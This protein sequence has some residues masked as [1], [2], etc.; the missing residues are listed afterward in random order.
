MVTEEDKKLMEQNIV[1]YQNRI[2]KNKAEI[3]NLED[4]NTRLERNIKSCQEVLD[5]DTSN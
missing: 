2:S 5:S 3:K 4:S 1:T